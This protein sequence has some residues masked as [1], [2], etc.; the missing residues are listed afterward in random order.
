MKFVLGSLTE[1]NE[2]VIAHGCNAQGVMGSGV[3]A[4]IRKDFPE[5]YEE[6]HAFFDPLTR[7][8]RGKHMGEAFFVET[9]G[10][11]IANC[12]TQFAFGSDGK[13]YANIEAV[14]ESIRA[15][16]DYCKEHEIEAYALP[17]IGCGLGGLEWPR[18]KLVIEEESTDAEPVVYH[19]GEIET[20]E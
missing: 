13:R 6:Y 4:Y 7:S 8:E 3:A 12:I 2:K 15:V 20:G 18:V 9:N 10:K 5:A 19:F 16:N 11:V 1:A 14:R 17:M